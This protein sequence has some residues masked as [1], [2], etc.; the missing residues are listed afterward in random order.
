MNFQQ[1]TEANAQL[2]DG[3][4]ELAAIVEQLDLND[5]GR[6]LRTRAGHVREDRFKVVVLGEF[7]RGKSTLLNAMLGDDLL[8]RR[9]TECTAIIT[10]IRHG[11]RPEYR[12]FFEDGTQ[13]S[14]SPNDFNEHYRLKIE[15]SEGREDALDRFSRIDHAVLSYPVELC[16]NGIELVDSPGLGAN[17][18]RT[19]R[20]HSFLSQAD[21]VVFVLYAPQFLKE[22]ESH[23][24]ENILLPLGLRNVF[25]VINGWNLIDEAVLRPEQADREREEL[26]QHIRRRLVPFCVVDGKDL[27]AERI[28]RVNA[29]KARMR[30]PVSAAMLEESDVPR[31]E[32]ALQKFLLEDRGRAKLEVVAGLIKGT[33][34]QVERV[35]ST[36]K[37][38]AGE[39]IE[40]VQREVAGVQPKLERLRGVRNHI[41]NYLDSQAMIL[42]DRLVVSFQHHMDRLERKLPEK[43]QGFD[44][45][46]LTGGS[47]VLK[48]LIDRF[49][50]E[51]NKIAKVAERCLQP[52]IQ[53]LV[54]SHFSEWQNA[55]CRN[56]MNAV[57]IDVDKHLQQEAAEYLRVMR[58]IEEQIGLHSHLPAIRELVDRWLRPE[59][60]QGAGSMELPMM[61][62]AGD[63]SFMIAA[64]SLDIGLELFFHMS[65]MLLPFVG[66]LLSSARLAMRE[67]DMRG[68]L[69]KEIETTLQAGLR[70]ATLKEAARLR[71]TVKAGFGKLKDKIV[72]SIDSEI[73]M[74]DANLQ[75]ILDR[76]RQAEYSAEAEAQTLAST[77]AA[78][79]ATVQRMQVV[80]AEGAGKG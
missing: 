64:V 36:R 13:E 71:D 38:M 53:K 76:R 43:I 15:D 27:S 49:R 50:E 55:V 30:K 35:I 68:R 78:L 72:G 61:Q 42:Q 9:V 63:L 51:E 33:V 8:P 47:M 60:G 28:F 22:A 24:L 66:I 4:D 34:D 10:V 12:V 20:T 40:D 80:A 11:D 77:Q 73:A 18:K 70:M 16:R 79:A 23:F 75:S 65:S 69:R 45:S 5:E 37:R 29:L 46:P 44:L 56:E 2:A 32:A 52:Q 74:I 54:E 57:A 62:V 19:R 41:T 6:R 21:A 1:A 67:V 26:E 17:P 58:E 7:K 59:P 31:F 39:S 25:F 3:F 14:V 48:A